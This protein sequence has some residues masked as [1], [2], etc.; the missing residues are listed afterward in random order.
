MNRS[1]TCFTWSSFLMKAFTVISWLKG[2]W[3]SLNVVLMY[4]DLAR[5]RNSSCWSAAKTRCLRLRTLRS[6]RRSSDG[7][8]S[9]ASSN[10]KSCGSLGL[11]L[12]RWRLAALPMFS[13]L[14]KVGHGMSSRSSN[15]MSS[16]MADAGLKTSATALALTLEVIFAA[17]AAPTSA[18]WLCALD[19]SSYTPLPRSM[20]LTLHGLT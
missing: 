3:H 12:W 15:R 20:T 2:P 6:A 7:I 8:R 5:A 4:Q 11:S 14:G 16:T 9:V 13:G 19:P 1:G 18:G 10:S 17:D